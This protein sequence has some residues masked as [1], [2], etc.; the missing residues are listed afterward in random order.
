MAKGREG[1]EEENRRRM[2]GMF[3]VI[4]VGSAYGLFSSSAAADII[5]FNKMMYFNEST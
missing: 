1:K 5:S 3:P 2:K 4:K